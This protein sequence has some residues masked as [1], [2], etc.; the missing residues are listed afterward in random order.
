MTEQLR[1]AL[2]AELRAALKEERVRQVALANRLGVS[3]KH[4]S[5]MLAAE[6]GSVAM[7]N[8]AA[9]AIGRTWVVFLVDDE[10]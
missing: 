3:Q 9:A 8:A 6:S 2:A 5:R 1:I 10:P 4:V 7:F